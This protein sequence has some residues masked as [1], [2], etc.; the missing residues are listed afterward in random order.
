M[1]TESFHVDG[2]RAYGLSTIDDAEYAAFSC[3]RTDLGDRHA[4]A[5]GGNDMADTDHARGRRDRCGEAADDGSTVML[6]EC[7]RDSID[8][9]AVALR[10]VR[11]TQAATVVLQVCCQHAFAGSPA[12]ALRDGT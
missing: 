12:Y 4:Q 6:V 11:P 2:Y 3:Q 9:N 7:D 5:R 8:D 10:D 1:A